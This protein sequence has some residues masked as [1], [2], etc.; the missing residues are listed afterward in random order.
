MVVDIS[1]VNCRS[2]PTIP[3]QGG[4]YTAR[5]V[6]MG[7]TGSGPDDSELPLSGGEGKMFELSPHSAALF[8]VK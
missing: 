3:P 5:N 7:L 8:A 1:V 4:R 6:W 2:R